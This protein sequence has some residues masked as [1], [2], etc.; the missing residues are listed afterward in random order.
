M[1]ELCYKKQPQNQ[2]KESTHSSKKTPFQLAAALC[3]AGLGLLLT[4]PLNAAAE[5]VNV[6]DTGARG[7]GVTMDT[8]A[9][10]KALDACKDEGG[11]VEFPAGTYLS[12][13][14]K[15]RASHIMIHLEPGATLLATTNQRDFM[16][17]PGDWLKAKSGSDFIPFLSG[18]DLTDVT[19]TGGGVI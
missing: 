15:I 1:Q 19:I 7:D 4:S 3:I 14:L 13:P 5:T 11:T 6:R 18:K 2:M 17:M 12:Q 16:K 9:I 8:A 10:Q